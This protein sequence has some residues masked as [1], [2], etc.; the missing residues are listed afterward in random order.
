MISCLMVESKIAVY[1][2]K[3]SF[4]KQLFAITALAHSAKTFVTF[5]FT[6]SKVR[7]D[8]YK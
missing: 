3:M 1:F 4:R 7:E 8:I 6:F 5:T 2:L